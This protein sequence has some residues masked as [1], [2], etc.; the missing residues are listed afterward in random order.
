MKFQLET[1]R[2]LNEDELI[3]IIVRLVREE[4]KACGAFVDAETKDFETKNMATL[5]HRHRK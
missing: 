3:T 5:C 2:A 1:G 4:R